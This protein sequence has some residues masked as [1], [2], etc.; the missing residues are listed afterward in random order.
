MKKAISV[1]ICMLLFV[2][3]FLVTATQNTMVTPSIS[4]AP[5]IY[6]TDEFAQ[7]KSINLKGKTAYAYEI[8]GLHIGPNSFDLDDPEGA[9]QII[10]SSTSPFAGTWINDVWY[11]I[12]AFTHILYTVDPVTGAESEIGPTGV[13]D[14]INIAGLAFDDI[15]QKAYGI[16]VSSQPI[17]T[18]FYEIDLTSGAATLIGDW[19]GD[20]LI[21]FACDSNGVFYGPGIASYSDTLYLID[22]TIPTATAIGP[23]G[24]DL[25]FAQGAAFDKDTDILYLAGYLSMTGGG[26]LYT[27]DTTTGYATLIGSFPLGFEFDALAIPYELTNKPP[28]TPVAPTGPD[29]GFKGIE[30]TFSASTTDP[31]GEPIYY[32]FDWGDGTNS[33]WVGPVDSG[34]IAS[35]Q[36]TYHIAGNFSVTVKAKDTNDHESGWSE[37]HSISI[38][39]QEAI[40]QIQ[41]ITGGLFIVTTQIKNIGTLPATKIN[42]TITLTKGAFIGKETKGSILSI[43]PGESVKISSKFIL[44]LGKTTIKVTASNP[45]T[46]DMKEQEGVILLFFI[47]L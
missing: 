28:E 2:P 46:S 23:I 15:T 29:T 1:L 42:W 33:S 12:S 20:I 41:T 18:R 8:S 9:T 34:A 43:A 19:N 25:N 40:I 36:H 27:C 6:N 3:V 24:L 47:K 13:E 17:F 45:D 35:A 26:R 39:E 38:T 37:G 22:P 32:L 16:F 21:D 7:I 11:I 30:Y 31:E 5:T 14:T 10:Y 4:F 44:G